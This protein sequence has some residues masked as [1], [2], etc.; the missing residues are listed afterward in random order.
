MSCGVP[1]NL[2]LDSG[3]GS[4][5]LQMLGL[6]QDPSP[7]HSPAFHQLPASFYICALSNYGYLHIPTL[8]KQM[9]FYSQWLP[10]PSG[11]TLKLLP[12][13]SARYTGTSEACWPLLPE[14]GQEPRSQAL[15]NSDLSPKAAWPWSVFCS[16][17]LNCVPITY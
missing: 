13:P 14:S 1:G 4:S 10:I 11:L 8:K 12:L 3:L 17:K 5:Y 6:T 2:R 15:L 7:S 16:S 9:G